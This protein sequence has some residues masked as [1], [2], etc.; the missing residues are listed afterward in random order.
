[1]RSVSQI[2][3]EAVSIRNNYLQF[4]ELNTG[5][6]NS[7]LSM[8]NLLTYVVAVCI[9]TYEAVLDLFEVKIAQVLTGRVNGTP[10][11]YALMAK[12]FQYNPV[13]QTGDELI[14]NEDT[15]KVEYANPDASRRIIEK[16]AW[17]RDENDGSL[18]LKACKSNTNSEE[19]NNGVPYMPLNDYELIAFK[20]YMQ[21]IRFVGADIYCESNPG[22]I[23]TIVADENNPIFYN[24]SYVTVSQALSSIKQAMIDFA[25][26]M[27]YDG[28]LYYQAILDVIRKTEHISDIG[29]NIKIYISEYNTLDRA[30]DEPV[31]LNGRAKLKSGYIRLLDINGVNVINK[32]NLT[33]IPASQMDEYNGSISSG[34]CNCDCDCGCCD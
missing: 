13:T 14:F 16:V 22:D 17:E 25:N 31:R 10:D 32:N 20:M 21:Q 15:L 9:H 4:T 27:E 12:K 2:Y 33:L 26:G 8:I 30:Y 24:D 28:Y 5:R 23:L 11:W 6:S 18:T 19:L 1:M 7:K 3:S 34:K 29:S